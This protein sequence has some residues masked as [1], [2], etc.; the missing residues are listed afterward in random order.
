MLYKNYEKLRGEN[1]DLFTG[2]DIRHIRIPKDTGIERYKKL[3]KK[4]GEL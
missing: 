3:I 4:Y 1:E 2:Q